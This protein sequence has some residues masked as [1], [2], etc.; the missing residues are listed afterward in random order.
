MPLRPPAQG[1]AHEGPGVTVTM[2]DGFEREEQTVIIDSVSIGSHVL[3]S[4][5]GA[6]T[7]D[8]ADMLLGRPLL[9][10]IGRFTIDS[11]NHKLIFG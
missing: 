1:F 7:P 10:Q 8:G 4:V 3:H 11:A 2:A 6:V 5:R 9:N